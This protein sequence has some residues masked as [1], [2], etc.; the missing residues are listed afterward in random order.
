MLNKTVIDRY[1]IILVNY[2]H[3]WRK[4]EVDIVN[5]LD[6]LGYLRGGKLKTF[7]RDIKPCVTHHLITAICDNIINMRMRVERVVYCTED[8]IGILDQWFEKPAVYRRYVAG[9]R[10]KLS[11]ILKVNMINIDTDFVEFSDCL[12]RGDGSC[13]D[14]ITPCLTQFDNVNLHELYRMVTNLGLKHIKNKFFS[15]QEYKK[16]LL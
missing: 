15:D 16:V 2:D 12:R 13:V 5:D 11:K 1:N 4:T 7:S 9:V 3:I 10:K 8:P 14:L 6:M